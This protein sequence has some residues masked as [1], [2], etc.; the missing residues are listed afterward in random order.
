[1]R[2]NL[3]K[4]IFIFVLMGIAFLGLHKDGGYGFWGGES[5]SASPAQT[6]T[7]VAETVMP[8][9]RSTP[10]AANTPIR[11]DNIGSAQNVF[12]KKL[13]LP[14]PKVKAEIALVADLETGQ[15]YYDKNSAKRWP[16]ASI[17]KL[18]SAEFALDQMQPD[19][20]ITI[21]EQEFQITGG[22]LAKGLKVGEQYTLDDL[23]HAMLVF[24]SNEA[25]EAIASSFGRDDFI[26]G[27]NLLADN[28]GMADTYLSDPTGLAAANQS[29][30]RDLMISAQ[31]IYR[32]RPEIFEMTRRPNIVLV[33][34][35]SGKAQTFTNINTF[36]GVA[37]FLGGKTGFTNEANGNL[38]SLF[39]FEKKPILVVVMGTP[40][41]FGETR[42]F[43]DWFKKSYAIANTGS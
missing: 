11:K 25:A 33:E 15:I 23:I 19:K 9:A 20:R 13:D 4:F 18:L 7:T 37:D 12:V 42:K 43:M 30:A 1:M 16:M 6:L 39:S 3:E 31:E 40:D 38:L 22:D 24:S 28:W 10:G 21:T 35:N 41:R 2:T 29:T 14:P 26:K 34:L 17:S 8:E 27:L 32:L 5:A 36:A